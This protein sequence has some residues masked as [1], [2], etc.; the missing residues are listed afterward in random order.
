MLG[1]SVW[2]Q[3]R[4]KT[5]SGEESSSSGCF[6]P[7]GRLQ[8]SLQLYLFMRTLVSKCTYVCPYLPTSVHMNVYAYVGMLN[9]EFEVSVPVLTVIYFMHVLLLIHCNIHT[10]CLQSGRH[11]YTSIPLL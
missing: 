8:Q 2:I 3:E 9:L 5:Q 11:T 7:V 6:N 4:L 10:E 1:K